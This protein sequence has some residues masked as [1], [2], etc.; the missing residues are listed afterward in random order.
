MKYG[1]S[2]VVLR[3]QYSG[4]FIMYVSNNKEEVM[5]IFRGSYALISVA[6][7]MLI[8]VSVATSAHGHKE[9]RAK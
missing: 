4:P 5:N 3:Q 6:V 8:T 9:R 7:C 2:E 1:F